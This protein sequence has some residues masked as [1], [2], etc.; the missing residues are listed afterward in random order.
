MESILTSIKNDLGIE[1][2]DKSFDKEIT[3][4]IN[5]AFMVL[6]QLGVGPAKGFRITSGLETWDEFLQGR[7]DLESVKDYVY[8]KVKLKFDSQSMSSST[9]E[10]FKEEAK[11]I[12]CRLN[13]QVESTNA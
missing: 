6:T 13:M 11:E 10:A 4:R 5:S 3:R 1:E 2:D 8:I 7:E 9:I 12:E